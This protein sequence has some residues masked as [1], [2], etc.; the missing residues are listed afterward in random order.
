MIA[1]PSLVKGGVVIMALALWTVVW[2][3]GK[4]EAPAETKALKN[5]VPQSEK[6]LAVARQIFETNCIFCHG[7]RGTGDGVAAGSLPVRP[8]DWTSPAT[9]GQADGE[10]YWK[11]TTGRSP[12]PSWSHLSDDDRWSLVHFIRTFRK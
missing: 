5:P 2:A 9:Q 8:A 7:P 11:I 12:M 4:W 6:A 1:H 3:Q 10:I